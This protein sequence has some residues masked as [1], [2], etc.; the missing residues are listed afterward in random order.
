MSDNR[1]GLNKDCHLRH[2]HPVCSTRSTRWNIEGLVLTIKDHYRA[3]TFSLPYSL[4]RMQ[5]VWLALFVFLVTRINMM[6]RRTPTTQISPT[7]IAHNNVDVQYSKEMYITGCI[8]RFLSNI[9]YL[10]FIYFIL[11]FLFYIFVFIFHSSFIIFIFIFHYL[12][13]PL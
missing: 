5:L 7:K 8:A 1:S 2:A 3:V 12:L 9:K 13:Q 4:S 6:P 11:Y 10:V